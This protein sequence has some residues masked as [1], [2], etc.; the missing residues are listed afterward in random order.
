MLKHLKNT[1]R[2]VAMY[3]QVLGQ[4]LLF[5]SVMCICSEVL[6]A[7]DIL[8][9]TTD[10]LVATLNGSGKTYLYIAEGVVSLA[11]YI[12]TKNILFLAG[13]VVVSIFFNVMMTVAGIT[14]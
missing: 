4:L 13:I 11:A 6:A 9:G 2:P 7:T 5:M 8:D 14:A 3:Y 1:T 10:G 12:K